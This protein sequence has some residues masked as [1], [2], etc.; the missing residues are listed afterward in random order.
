MNSSSVENSIQEI[1]NKLNGFIY[2][3]DKR[4]TSNT[5]GIRIVNQRINELLEQRHAL[6]MRLRGEDNNPQV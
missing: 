1:D 6:A 4:G 2:Y 3:R 5:S